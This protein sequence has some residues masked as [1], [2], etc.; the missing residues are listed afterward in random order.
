[1]S[2]YDPQLP[3]TVR[4]IRE[5]NSFFNNGVGSANN[6]SKCCEGCNVE[7]EKR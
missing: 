3:L 2:M 6:T 1:M 5:S 4:S 7:K